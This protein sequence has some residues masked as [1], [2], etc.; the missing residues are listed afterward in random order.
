MKAQTDFKIAQLADA[1]VLLGL[2]REF[3]EYEHLNFDAGQA[4]KSLK[5]LLSDKSLGRVWLIKE[6]GEIAGYM[7]V[8]LGFSLEFH[9]RDAF[10]DELY[11]RER[12]RG[13]GLGKDALLRAEAFCREANVKAL[14][15]EVERQNTK[16]QTFYRKVGF[17]DHDRY[18]LTKW[19]FED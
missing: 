10:L 8:T 16:A 11:F 2:M 3:Y 17:R 13:R 6:A 15:L 7:A 9:G 5:M 1:P 4:E 12:F 14:H 19:I 18:L